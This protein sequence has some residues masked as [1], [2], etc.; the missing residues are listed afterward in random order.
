MTL[1]EPAHKIFRLMLVQ[2]QKVAEEMKD[3]F[4]GSF[5]RASMDDIEF[6]YTPCLHIQT[7]QVAETYGHRVDSFKK[8][9]AARL[10]D[11]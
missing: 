1:G 6:D 4:T 3:A 8:G 5:V 11:K 7:F 2:P 9:L 10:G